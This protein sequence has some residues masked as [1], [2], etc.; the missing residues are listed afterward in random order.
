MRRWLV[1]AVAFARG[2]YTA[3]AMAEPE[4]VAG[5]WQQANAA[6]QAG[7]ADKALA[8]LASLPEGGANIAEAESLQCRL[9]VHDGALGCRSKSLRTGLCNWM[10]R[11]P[12]A[13]CGWAGPRRKGQPRH[14]LQCILSRQAGVG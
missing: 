1:T 2:C 8:L 12:D 4:P 11:T 9:A 7:E 14:V 10:R 3:M 6:L 13:T 5:T